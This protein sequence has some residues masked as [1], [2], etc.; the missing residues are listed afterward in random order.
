MYDSTN[1][2]ILN[3]WRSVNG[4]KQQKGPIP[5]VQ[6]NGDANLLRKY[7]GKGLTLEVNPVE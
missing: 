3:L 1:V 7:S 6:K 2:I 4:K 5:I